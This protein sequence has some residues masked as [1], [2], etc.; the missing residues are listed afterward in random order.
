MKWLLL[1]ELTIGYGAELEF[2]NIKV[3]R[4]TN[5]RTTKIQKIK[6]MSVQYEHGSPVAHKLTDSEAA[7]A[8]SFH[9]TS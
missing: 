7:L 3:E 5:N 9:I 4:R 6:H 8:K 1:T 2:R